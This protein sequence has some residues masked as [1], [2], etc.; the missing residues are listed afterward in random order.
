M[1]HLV[2]SDA[3]AK[4]NNVVADGAG[5]IGDVGLGSFCHATDAVN[6]H[7]CYELNDLTPGEKN[8]DS[9]HKVAS[10]MEHLPCE[11]KSS[12]LTLEPVD[13]DKHMKELN[14][15]CTKDCKE[16]GGECFSPIPCN[17]PS[18]IV[19]KNCSAPT[20]TSEFNCE[21]VWIND[22]Q[23]HSK[24]NESPS[25]EQLDNHLSDEPNGDKSSQELM[26]NSEN[27]HSNC[28]GSLLADDTG[29]A[30]LHAMPINA[31]SEELS[32]IDQKFLKPMVDELNVCDV[33]GDS[34]RK[35]KA[36]AQRPQLQ[37]KIQSDWEGTGSYFYATQQSD[38][39]LS[40]D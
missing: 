6:A 29:I 18:V 19:D 8:V 24:E 38:H 14:G 21:E 31:G 37:R 20:V 35:K 32:D 10:G 2:F 16:V 25:H 13:G 1:E 22:L 26:E 33:P 40:S 30:C 3:T 28:C 4:L 5:A 34:K 27:V 15:T 7:E 11:H 39:S 9:I 12:L 17:C 36:K 23:I